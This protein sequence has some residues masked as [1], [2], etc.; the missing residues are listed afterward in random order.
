M[1]E[2]KGVKEVAIAKNGNFVFPDVRL[3]DGSDF[4]VA[5]K[6]TPAGQKC[7]I[8]AIN[9]TPDSDTLNIVAVSCTKKGRH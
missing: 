7:Q 6:A 3:P 5:I 9:T 8:E 1:L 2:L 4:N